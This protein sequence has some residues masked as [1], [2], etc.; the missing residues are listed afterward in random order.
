MKKILSTILAASMM[1]IGAQAFA[2]VSVGAGYANSTKTYKADGENS[3]SA[4]NGFYAELGYFVDFGG[5]FGIEPGLRYTYFTGND[6]INLGNVF[7]AK[8]NTT[9]MYLDVPVHLKMSAELVPGFNAFVFAGPTFSLGVSYTS[10]SS[11]SILGYEVKGDRTDL[12]SDDY[13]NRF[14]ILVGGGIGVDIKNMIRVKVGYD[15]GCLNRLNSDNLTLNR[16]QLT[17]G[18]AIL[19]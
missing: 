15:L 12:Y 3:S 16:N 18:I 9:D 17:A 2:Q 11:A 10:K 5:G 14:D 1:L 13:Y 8:Q 6:K 7:S 19:F 4:S